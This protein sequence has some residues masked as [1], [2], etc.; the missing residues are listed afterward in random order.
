MPTAP[1]QIAAGPE[2]RTAAVRWMNVGHALLLRG[3]ATALEGAL[4]AYREAVA[5]LCHGPTDTDAAWAN[6]LGAALLNHAQLLVQVRGASAA[7]AALRDLDAA[8][9][10]LASHL[11]GGHAWV[12]RNLAGV[13]IN[14]ATLRL[15]AGQPEAARADAE[16]ALSLVAAGERE[17]PNDAELSLKARRAACSALGLLLP[18]FAASQQDEVARRAS[19]LVDEAVALVA[20]WKAR[21]VDRLSA[22]ALRLIRFGAELYRRHQP[23][24]LVEFLREAA[25]AVSPADA[26]EMGAIMRASLDG[27]LT[28][29]ARTGWY[30]LGDPATE[31]AL[32]TRREISAALG[33]HPHFSG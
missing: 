12:R 15:C 1:I 31:Q 10:V 23:H 22:V 19:D 18:G 8:E 29:S 27:A 21:R 7:D 9:A 26:T 33:L 14:R 20:Y 30:A 28:D 11:A 17:D 3:D 32:A 6:S 2:T 4:D 25:D 13:R 5:L 16:A 24:F